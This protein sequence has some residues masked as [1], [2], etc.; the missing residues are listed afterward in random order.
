M[1]A[2][3]FH[4]VTIHSPP[5]L[6]KTGA[7]ILV[8]NHVSGLDPVVVQAACNRIVMWMMAREY[9]EI[10]AMQWFFKII[11]AI[12]VERSGRDLASTRAALRG[13]AAGR[14]LGIF[15]E[16][17]LATTRDLLPFQTGVA[18]LAIKTGAPVFPTYIDGGH[19]HARGMVQAFVQSSEISLRFGEAVEIDRSST[20]KEN[21]ERATEKIQR[22]VEKLRSKN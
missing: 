13:L 22:A 5:R 15:P 3:M 10:K 7:A 12:P 2:R 18:M 21:L 16:G 17:R 14:V 11:E 19:R 1:Y 20:S 6:P 8:C 9:Y 4:R